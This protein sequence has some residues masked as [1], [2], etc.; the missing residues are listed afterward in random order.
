VILPDPPDAELAEF[1]EGWAKRKPYNVRR[2]P[3]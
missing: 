1:L 2:K 3:A